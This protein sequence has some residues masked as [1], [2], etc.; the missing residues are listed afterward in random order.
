M[1]KKKNA[2]HASRTEREQP[3]SSKKERR[4]EPASCCR[5]AG[6]RGKASRGRSRPSYQARYSTVSEEGRPVGSNG[7]K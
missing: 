1:K 6:R 2:T 7:T 4:N 5:L 3:A